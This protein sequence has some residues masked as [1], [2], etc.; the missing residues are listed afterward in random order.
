MDAGTK[1][2]V[3]MGAV[4]GG[5]LGAYA[6]TMWL[7]GRANKGGGAPRL[8]VSGAC[9]GCKRAMLP[10]WTS[11]LFCGW[12]PVARLEFIHGPKAGTSV[13]LRED[14]TT[15]GSV[16]GNTVVLLDPGVSRRHAGIRRDEHGYEVADLGSTNGIYVNGQRVPKQRLAPG[17][18][19]R[20]GNSE[21][22]FRAA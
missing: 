19:V 20:I 7:A 1:Q 17:D 10:T 15:L 13:D 21:A 8:K 16:D 5:V 2:L 18:V 4:V 11:C 22:V 12:S 14:V 9:G 3:I 6:L